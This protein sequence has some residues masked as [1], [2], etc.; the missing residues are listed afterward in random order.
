M[1]ITN[2][3]DFILIRRASLKIGKHMIFQQL[4]KQTLSCHTH[5][6]EISFSYLFYPKTYFH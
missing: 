2:E 1:F 6:V 4:E 3:K 5:I